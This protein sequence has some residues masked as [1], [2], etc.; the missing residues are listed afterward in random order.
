MLDKDLRDTRCY[1]RC[2][3]EPRDIGGDFSRAAVTGAN[4]K[5]CW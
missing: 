4:L 2:A 1:S 5:V 3:N